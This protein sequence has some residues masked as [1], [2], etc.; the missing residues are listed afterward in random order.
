[1]HVPKQ[2]PHAI[3]CYCPAA[4]RCNE[5]VCNYAGADGQTS[6]AAHAGKEAHRNQALKIRSERTTECESA[7]EDIAK[8]EDD[9]TAVDFGE[10]GEEERSELVHLV[11]V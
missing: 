5:E 8:V 1:M 2:Y 6:A 3:D 10:W 4:L 11:S 7:E 9:T